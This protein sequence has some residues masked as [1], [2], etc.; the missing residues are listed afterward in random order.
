MRLPI[1][2]SRYFPRKEPM[3]QP[4]AHALMAAQ[5]L[6]RHQA[7][8]SHS[9]LSTVFWVF[10][11]HF[12]HST[13]ISPGLLQSAFPIHGQ[14]LLKS[15]PLSPRT[16]IFTSPL[17]SYFPTPAWG[18]LSFAPTLIFW[19][20]KDLLL[21]AKV[22]ATNNQQ[23]DQ[24]FVATERNQ[25]AHLSEG[26]VSFRIHILQKTTLLSPFLSLW[27]MGNSQVQALK[28][29]WQVLLPSAH[30][31]LYII[32]YHICIRNLQRTA[33]QNLMIFGNK[34][35]TELGLSTLPR[36]FPFTLDSSPTDCS[37]R[38]WNLGYRTSISFH[39]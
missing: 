2:L 12:P 3:T 28:F 22:P 7:S 4:R 10:P 23:S 19:P 20:W 16:F 39:S 26:S 33:F 14:F 35:G 25:E 34:L 11:H 18:F 13:A 1:L 37:F 6:L 5:V 15:W 30:V 17:V 29:P 36:W 27:E 32:G 9:P 38:A 8:L 31:S 24:I 21:S